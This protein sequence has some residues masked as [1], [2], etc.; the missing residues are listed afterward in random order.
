MQTLMEKQSKEIQHLIEI[1]Q[2][3]AVSFVSEEKKEP[4]KDLGDKIQ[5]Y[6]NFSKTLVYCVMTGITVYKL[7]CKT[8]QH[9]ELKAPV[10]QATQKPTRSYDNPFDY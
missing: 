3:D 2:D 6:T 4:L 5:E 7:L 10:P 9:V 8:V 1:L